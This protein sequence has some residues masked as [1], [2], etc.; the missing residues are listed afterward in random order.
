ME[1]I[2]RRKSVRVGAGFAL[3]VLFA[4]TVG[5]QER[6]DRTMPGSVGARQLDAP[7]AVN[8]ATLNRLHP[9]LMGAHGR[10]LV[11]VRLKSSALVDGVAAVEAEQSEFLARCLAT[12][13]GIDVVAQVQLVLNAVFLEVDAEALPAI[14]R[15]P[16]VSVVRP[17]GNYEKVLSETVPYIGS[18]TLQGI[19][20]DGTGVSIAVLDSGIDYTHAN[21]GGPGT[22]G[23]YN[24]AYADFTS[25][26]G[27]FPTAK[28][29]EGF[30]FVGEEW[31]S[32]PL[33][34]DDDPIDFDGHGT[35]V[36]DISGG[37]GGVA[38]GADLTP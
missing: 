24:A 14:A 21:L 25:R 38:P 19:G 2:R 9:S 8:G 6:E 28:V 12:L 34:P 13:P 4:G 1:H 16:L 20:L 36:A 23:A 15:D 17:V 35:H 7:L 26:D 27:L 33:L 29:V 5:A 30:D 31:P 10:E 18:T 3:G 11:I 37:L 22:L 32:G